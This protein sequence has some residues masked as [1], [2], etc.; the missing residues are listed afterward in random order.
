MTAKCTEEKIFTWNC[1][2]GRILTQIFTQNLASQVAEERKFSKKICCLKG[3]IFW[4]MN[5][6]ER[7]FFTRLG[8]FKGREREREYWENVSMKLDYST[9]R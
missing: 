6:S 8:C 4:K 7:E 5:Y 3:R 9:G 2:N 1:S